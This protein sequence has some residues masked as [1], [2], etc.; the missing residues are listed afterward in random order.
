M[1]SAKPALHAGTS[2]S[3]LAWPAAVLAIAALSALTWFLVI[4]VAKHLL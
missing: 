2:G 1:S 4:A 3:P